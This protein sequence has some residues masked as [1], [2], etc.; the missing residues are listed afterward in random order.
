MAG[1]NR[2]RIEIALAIAL[3]TSLAVP[4]KGAGNDWFTFKGN[5]MRTSA[6][7]QFVEP[8]VMK[9]NWKQNLKSEISA[10][11]V[12]YGTDCFVAT[13]GEGK[14]VLYS[15]DA[16]DGTI[17]WKFPE[18]Q[19]NWL[20]DYTENGEKPWPN[21]AI[22]FPKAKLTISPTV[23]GKIYMPWGQNLL[24]LN[25]DSGRLVHRYN[26][27]IQSA[28]VTTSPVISETFQIVVVGASNGY[29][30]GFDLK[31]RDPAIR[32][33]LPDLGTDGVIR[34]SPAFYGNC[35]YFGS[36][37][38]NFYCIE[39]KPPY[40]KNKGIVQQSEK[41][42]V[43]WQVKLN[44][45]INSSPAYS[46]G[47]VVVTTESGS[48]YALSDRDGSTIWKYDVGDKKIESSP[49]IAR[50]NIVFAAEKTLYCITEAKG[51]FVWSTNVKKNIVSTPSIGG[52]YVYFTTTEG[53]M[54]VVRLST[55]ATLSAKIIDN[56]IRSSPAIALNNV[57][58]GA[59]DG[60]IYSLA[61][62]D[63][64]PELGLEISEIVVTSLP[65]NKTTTKTFD[66]QN[67]GGGKLDVEILSSRSW[68]TVDPGKF[69][70]NSGEFKEITVTF[71]AK[72][73]QANTYN[74][75]L[76][77][78]TNGGNANVNVSVNIIR[79]PSTYVT[80]TVGSKTAFLSGAPITLAVA[81][82]K[83]PP[84][85][86]VTMVPVRFVE[87]AF[88]CS[89]SWDSATKKT[90]LEYEKRKVKVTFSIGKSACVIQ[91]GD[92]KPS[93]QSMFYPATIKES[94]TCVPI[95]F[96]AWVFGALIEYKPNTPNIEITIPGD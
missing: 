52:D 82:W 28:S 55:G 9:V 96:M 75:I 37:S 88:G 5:Y 61:N 53:K 4:A 3:L 33:R 72:N 57:Y 87:D 60:F 18:N 70:L 8:P 13:E 85:A 38:K 19:S 77:I 42:T 17:Q 39:M 41:P 58:I 6:T 49:A 65:V 26:L 44:G 80:M 2:L 66:I 23:D 54:M 56:P 7:N 14:G 25:A 78:N 64:A 79:N 45:A 46:A 90:T 51:D 74:A 86:I 73:Q 16:S 84:P 94:R 93:I 22:D 95:D 67:K 29:L 40:D 35:L 91:L 83:S 15:L 24:V 71:D 11:P 34:S 1:S 27:A 20:A 63:S 48:V 89:V 10:S 69:T 59:D 62:G 92:G 36:S 31:N 21:G 68:I 47:K 81:P 32:W 50:G 76:R 30:Y 43:K 12:I